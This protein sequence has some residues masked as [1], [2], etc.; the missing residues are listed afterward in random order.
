MT[1][2]QCTGRFEERAGSCPAGIHPMDGHHAR[3]ALGLDPLD[4]PNQTIGN[5]QAT[6]RGRRSKAMLFQPYVLNNR[7]LLEPAQTTAAKAK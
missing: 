2:A 6:D 3:S 7:V 1:G 5:T 4:K